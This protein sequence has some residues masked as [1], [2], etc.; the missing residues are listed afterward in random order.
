MGGRGGAGGLGE[1]G[2][3]SGPGGGGG[4]GGGGPAQA[5]RGGEGA[6]CWAL[7]VA[8]AWA[9]RAEGGGGGMS[10]TRWWRGRRWRRGRRGRV[11]GGGSGGMAG[12][13]GCVSGT[14]R[15]VAGVIETCSAT[16]TWQSTGTSTRELL[17]NPAFEGGETGW[18]ISVAGGFP[19]LYVAND[20]SGSNPEIVAQSPPILAWFAGSRADDVLSQTI[21]LPANA[22]SM[23]VSF[24][25]AIFTQ[26]VSAAE[27]D[28]MDVQL[29]A[30]AQTI[31]LAHFSDN[32]PVGTWTRFSAPLPASLAGQTVTL[33][34]HDTTNATLI[35]SF[36]VD[37]VSVRA[38]ACP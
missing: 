25:Y 17:A 34:F 14:N 28:V 10:G 36:Y 19:L 18:M 38:V 31:S 12:T 6:A 26:E 24:Y 33:R 32:S 23:T 30:G 29:I 37:T 1:S 16:G 11:G 22:A 8:A 2:G 13:G 3:I 5:G 27:S 7:V 15:C 21:V 35:T 9:G 20:T 4:G